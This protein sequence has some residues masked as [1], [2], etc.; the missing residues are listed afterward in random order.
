MKIEC[1]AKREGGSLIDIGDTEYHFKPIADGAHVADVANEEH[2]ERFLSIR[3]TY[4]IYKKGGSEKN[5]E[6]ADE[7]TSGESAEP[8][9][10]AVVDVEA[11]KQAYLEKFGKLPHH[12]LG[13]DKIKAALAE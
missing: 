11:L 9:D 13:I 1:K 10:V 3:D 4:C 8:E 7:Q 6:S 5:T 12:K 2:I